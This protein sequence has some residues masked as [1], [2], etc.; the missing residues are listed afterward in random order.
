MLIIVGTSSTA[1]I[2]S[3]AIACSVETGS[4]P[5]TMTCV[6]ATAVAQRQKMLSAAWN[7]GAA[8]RQRL[9]LS[10]PKPGRHWSTF[11]TTARWL[12]MTPFDRPVVPP[13]YMSCAM[14]SPP[15]PASAT[16]GDAASS[17]S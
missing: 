4:K 2:R 5:G 1:L 8:W 16:A 13:V 7:I 3:A 17:A 14:S 10:M 9:P 15:R 6:A 11:D 12:N